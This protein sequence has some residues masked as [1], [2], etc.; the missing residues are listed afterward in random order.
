M[1]YDVILG[2]LLLTDFTMLKILLTAIVT[3]MIGVYLFWQIGLVELHPKAGSLGSSVLGGLIFGVGFGLLGYCPG[4][5]MGAAGE[6]YLDALLGGIPGVLLGASL[7]A[8]LYPRLEKIVLKK[9]DIG[10]VTVPELLKIN[11][12]RIITPFCLI[13]IILL[14]WLEKAGL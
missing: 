14:I 12:W 5:L 7:F 3:G 2:Q 6:G 4:T 1:Q 13:I 11:P 9:G 8:A 10:T